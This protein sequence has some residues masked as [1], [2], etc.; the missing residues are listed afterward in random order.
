MR[1]HIAL[2]DASVPAPGKRSLLRLEGKTIALFNVDEILYAIDDSCPH[3]GGSLL[4]GK[5]DGRIL[6][7]PAHGLK[8][9]LHTGCMAGGKG[10]AARR[11]AVGLVN[12]SMT[13][14]IPDSTY[15]DPSP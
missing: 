1:R 3:A 8:F 12:G 7:C 10:L 5:L 11:Y 4:M 6:Q 2:P 14:V 15:L 9:D 13:I